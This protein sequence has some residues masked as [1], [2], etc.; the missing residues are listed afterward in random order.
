[1]VVG[2]E[3]VSS[4]GVRFSRS[5]AQRATASQHGRRM[6]QGSIKSVFFKHDRVLPPNALIVVGHAVLGV[7]Y[8]NPVDIH[9]DVA[10]GRAGC[11]TG[12]GPGIVRNLEQPVSVSGNG[13]VAVG[14]G[15]DV[16]RRDSGGDDIGC[17]RVRPD[18]LDVGGEC[19]DDR[20]DISV[21]AGAC[22]TRLV[23]TERCQRRMWHSR[24]HE[25]ITRIRSDDIPVCCH[26]RGR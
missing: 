6:S 1:M 10:E 23:D 24:N 16:V 11:R 7:V 15:P 9:A 26:Q 13:R 21:R 8:R 2:T 18:R 12:I 5:E 22:C 20:I 17:L 25:V 3:F 14:P 4:D 19:T